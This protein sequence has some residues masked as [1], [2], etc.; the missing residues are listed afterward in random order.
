MSA[1]VRICDALIITSLLQVSGQNTVTCSC[2]KSSLL[3]YR[4]TVGKMKWM[5]IKIRLSSTSVLKL[6]RKWI[7]LNISVYHRSR[8][9]ACVCPSAC[10][11]VW[12]RLSSLQ[13]FTRSSAPTAILRVWWASATAASNVIITSSVR[14]ASGGGM[15]VVPIATST[16]WRSIRHG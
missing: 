10:V 5:L 13:S 11:F 15:P 2:I 16:K 9:C 14:T 6:S 4:C 1:F 12:P 7:L 3:S 8:L